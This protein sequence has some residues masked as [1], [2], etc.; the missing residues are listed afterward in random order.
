MKLVPVT[1]L[2]VISI[3]II[4]SAQTVYI[5][6]SGSK[7]H[8][9]NCSY[10]SK[11][12]ISIDLSEAKEKGFT[13][14]SR[15]KPDSKVDGEVDIEKETDSQKEIEKKTTTT[16]RQCEAIT[17]KGTRCKRNAKEGSKYCWQ[18]KN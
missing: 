13:P 6:K 11:S 10:L 18:H 17:K 9:S 5:T 14:C 1:F 8:L 4:A 2:L 15:C 3:S 12:K 16:S 7:Y